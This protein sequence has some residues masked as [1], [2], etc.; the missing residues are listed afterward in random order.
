MFTMK[1]GI[2]LEPTITKLIH[3]RPRKRPRPMTRTRI[4]PGR[5]IN[6]QETSRNTATY[7][8]VT[9]IILLDVVA[10]GRSWQLSSKLE[11]S[12]EA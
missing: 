7:I 6:P 1:D 8:R 2:F 4:L 3:L 10:S 5:R 11:K 12:V 9:T